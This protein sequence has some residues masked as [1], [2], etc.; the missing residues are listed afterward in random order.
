[1]GI[2]QGD[3][4]PQVGRETIEVIAIATGHCHRRCTDD[5]CAV[6]AKPAVK[7]DGRSRANQCEKVVTSVCIKSDTGGCSTHSIVSKR[8]CASATIKRYIS[9]VPT[10]DSQRVCISTATKDYRGDTAAVVDQRIGSVVPSEIETGD[11]DTIVDQDVV[12]CAARKAERNNGRIV[13]QRIVVRTPAKCQRCNWPVIDQRVFIRSASKGKCTDR[14]G[15]L[16]YVIVRTAVECQTGHRTK[17]EQRV[18]SIVTSKSQCLDI[19]TSIEQ[20]I[21]IRTAVERK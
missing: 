2:R 3:I 16:Q 7:I 12:I 15:V 20:N 4:G 9:Y 5:Q 14:C 10:L 11:T 13:L 17:I 6:V 8:I 1:M 18:D 21:V 19:Q